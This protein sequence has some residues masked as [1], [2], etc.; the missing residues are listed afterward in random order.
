MD[1]HQQPHTQLESA[2]NEFFA[3]PLLPM[4]RYIGMRFADSNEKAS[5]TFSSSNGRL[6]H[7]CLDS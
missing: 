5:D 1:N 4:F 3:I 2:E 7:H 6:L